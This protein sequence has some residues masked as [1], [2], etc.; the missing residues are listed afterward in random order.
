[1]TEAFLKKIQSTEDL[2]IGSDI[3]LNSLTGETEKQKFGRQSANILRPFA[4]QL[5]GKTLL[6]TGDYPIWALYLASLDLQVTII[7]PN[8]E[9][10]RLCDLICTDGSGIQRINSIAELETRTAFSAAIIAEEI[11][12][13]E[14]VE[15]LIGSFLEAGATQVLIPFH[16]LA[17]DEP[18]KSLLSDPENFC[19]LP[20]KSL[21]FSEKSNIGVSE[22]INHKALDYD[23]LS[24]NKTINTFNEKRFADLQASILVSREN[25]ET[26]N[27]DDLIFYF[28]DSRREALC[29]TTKICKRAD[30]DFFVSRSKM[31]SGE[32]AHPQFSQ[33][34]ED[35]KFLKGQMLSGTLTTL[36]Q[37]KWEEAEICNWAAPWVKKLAENSRLEQEVPLVPRNF[38]D[39]VPFNLMSDKDG[40]IIPFDLEYVF[41]QEIP[42]KTVLFRGLFYSLLNSNWSLYSGEHWQLSALVMD[43]MERLGYALS[44][45]ELKDILNFENDF[46]SFVSKP[47]KRSY[48][49]DMWMTLIENRSR[50][51]SSFYR[52]RQLR[53][54][55]HRHLS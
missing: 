12:S 4:N 13:T 26:L 39:F 1:M 30:G 6:S 37:S 14:Q 31:F 2:S 36:Q 27:E 11:S 54:I 53:K 20:V 16:T 5:S 35:E 18:R 3:L 17:F 28:S 49:F 8:P 10:A 44:N 7:E 40:Q 42:L 23:V 21:Y 19:G 15:N 52:K 29:K 32:Y 48:G 46:Q 9:K 55:Y 24:D 41:Y 43:I 38:I 51:L 22:I 45:E 33:N 25:E 34:V 47:K 50:S